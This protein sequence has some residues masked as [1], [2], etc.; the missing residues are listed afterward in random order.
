MLKSFAHSEKK[1]QDNNDHKSRQRMERQ[2]AI[3]QT[4]TG[5]CIQKQHIKER[6][7]ENELTSSVLTSEGLSSSSEPSLSGK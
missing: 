7:R 4:K 1:M 3:L 5:I 2:L 6:E